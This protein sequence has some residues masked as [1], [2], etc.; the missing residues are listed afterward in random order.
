MKHVK[1]NFDTVNPAFIDYLLNGLMGLGDVDEECDK[2]SHIES[3]NRDQ[4]KNLIRT[5][6]QPEYEG[7]TTAYQQTVKFNLSYYLTTNTIDFERVFNSNLLPIDCPQPARLF[8][9]WMWQVYYPDEDYIMREIKPYKTRRDIYEPGRM[10]ANNY[11]PRP[12]F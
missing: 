11:K 8:F 12:E 9:E 2:L 4:V 6:L 5:Y 3:S 7:G 1:P 10:W